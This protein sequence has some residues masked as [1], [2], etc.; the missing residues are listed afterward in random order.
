MEKKMK[1]NDYGLCG[2]SQD[3]VIEELR[4][5]P[6][7]DIEKLLLEDSEY[8]D[9]VKN[10]Y[11]YE[12]PTTKIY[13]DKLNI[14][15]SEFHNSLN[16]EWLMPEEYTNMNIISYINGLCKTP[17]EL[18]RAHIELELYAKFEL[19]DL[20]RYLKYLRDTAIKNNVVWGVGRGSSCCSYVLY[21]LGIHKVNSILYDL[22]IEDFLRN[23]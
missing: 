12:L 2:V 3:E 21:L 7:L 15:P 19:I 13:T 17:E 11:A 16:K 20:L 22:K 8:N 23:K 18:D 10:T 5:N 1:I 4:K 6:N 14:S 9:N